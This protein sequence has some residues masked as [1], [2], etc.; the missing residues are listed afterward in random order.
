[1]WSARLAPV[2]VK[3]ALR[4]WLG[5]GARLDCLATRRPLQG[6]LAASEPGR[7]EG[8]LPHLV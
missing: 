8:Q 5:V 4:L 7:Q 3:G 6:G 1:M 2:W